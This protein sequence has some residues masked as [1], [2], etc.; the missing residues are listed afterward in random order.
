MNQLSKTLLIICLFLAFTGCPA[1]DK[2]ASGGQTQESSHVSNP[3]KSI[4]V[5][6]TLFRRFAIGGES[7]GTGLKLADGTSIEIDLATN[8][9]MPQF[10]DGLK[11]TISGTYKT[12]KGI[13][14]TERRILVV[15][16]IKE[17]K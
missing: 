16:T 7:T 2:K 12:V 4:T 9:L 13:E 6:G 17:S 1:P 14:I 11:V 15:A 10:R 8:Q 5:A 3:G